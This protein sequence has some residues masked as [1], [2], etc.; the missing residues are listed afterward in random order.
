MF[1]SS[2]PSA[3]SKKEL[4][5]V[6]EF[7]KKQEKATKAAAAASSVS[8]ILEE[9][10]KFIARKGRVLYGGAAIN[11]LLPAKAQ[12]YNYAAENP[13]YDF[14]TPDAVADCRELVTYFTRK[15]HQSVEAKPGVHLGT[16]KVFVDY[17]GVADIT[18]IDSRVYQAVYKQSVIVDGLRYSDPNYLRMGAYLELSRPEGD[19]TRWKKV[20]ERVHLLNKYWPILERS[21]AKRKCERPPLKPKAADETI[22]TANR[23]VL[24]YVKAKDR[25][26]FGRKA[27]Q[28]YQN[29]TS[30]WHER[31]IGASK[32]GALDVIHIISTDIDTD[33]AAIGKILVNAGICKSV[34]GREFGIVWENI[35]RHI[36]IRAGPI[37]VF[38]YEP[39]G[40]Q[41]YYDVELTHGSGEKFHV[42]SPE[43]IM[44]LYFGFLYS[45]HFILDRDEI[46]C[47][48]NML[49]QLYREVKMGRWRQLESF[50]TK[51]IG[52]Q[53][54]LIDMRIHAIQMRKKLAPKKGTAEYNRYFFT[55]N[56]DDVHSSSSKSQSTKSF[57]KKLSPNKTNSSKLKTIK[58]RK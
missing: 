10:R 1:G 31:D 40:C 44:N 13:D 46:L 51:C 2:G 3:A 24:D 21:E 29:L 18:Q 58:S 39:N 17:N 56:Q 43:T 38:L 22:I 54:S 6:D 55:M 9:V 8:Q 28:Y 53:E 35:P 42:A 23:H 57:T 7:A 27:V 41:S 52:H 36:E 47:A 34:S 49:S 37:R 25:I 30:F 11:G 12:F 14:L 4:Q 32:Y 48:T 50:T 26:L 15:G 20:Y 45:P 16:F 19:S 5:L 33:Y